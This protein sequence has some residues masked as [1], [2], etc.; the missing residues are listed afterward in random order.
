VEFKDSDVHWFSDGQKCRT[1]KAERLS[2]VRFGLLREKS[3]ELVEHY[4]KHRRKIGDNLMA[5]ALGNTDSAP[6]VSR[7]NP[8]NES[9]TMAKTRVQIIVASPKNWGASLCPQWRPELRSTKWQR[10]W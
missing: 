5:Q 9:Q 3:H 7:K 8:L 10:I 1:T 2:G 4:Q 6:I